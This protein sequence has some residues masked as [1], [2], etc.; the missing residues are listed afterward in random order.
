MLARSA[1]MGL[2]VLGA[3]LI[4]HPAWSQDETE[5]GE[6]Q[7]VSESGSQA[8]S[9]A[10]EASDEDTAGSRKSEGGG[11]D[12]EA[13]VADIERG[14]SQVEVEGQTY[15]FVGARY[16]FIL[17]PQ[18]IMGMFADGGT[19]VGVHS[20]GA[21]FVVRRNN[22]EYDFALWLAG[23]SMD[24]TPFKAKTDAEDA[25]ELVESRMKVLYLTADFLWSQ[26]LSPEFAINYGMGAGFGL[27][28]GPLYRNQAYRT[29]DGSYAPCI[30]QLNPSPFYCGQDNDHYNNYE[31]PAW[32]KGSKPVVFPW[33]A[34]QTGVRYK[35]HRNFVARFDAGFGLSGF[36]FGVGADYGL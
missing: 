31:E 25:W 22:F 1:L 24:P 21:E 20:G 3:S 6:S 9:E 30:D 23:Y 7:D 28:F 12:E 34:L 33:L 36:F 16:R 4:A 14:G 27:V 26:V 8:D 35:P 11:S 17:V 15:L 2:T 19:T 32:T 18:F 29:P 13:L 10:E 5:G